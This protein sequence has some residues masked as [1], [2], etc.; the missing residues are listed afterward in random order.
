MS[1]TDQMILRA[2]MAALVLAVVSAS[3]AL[4]QRGGRGAALLAHTP[5]GGQP[6]AAA[7]DPAI[8][9]DG[10][11]DRYAAYS[12]AATDIVRGSGAHRNIF[13]VYRRTP[14]TKT[15]SPWNMGKTVLITKGRGGP[16]NG[17]SWGPSFD[18]YDYAHAGREI[19]VAPKCLAFVSAASNLVRGDGNH[20]ADVFVRRMRGGRLTRIAT[21]GS[22]SEVA[23][24]GR[25]WFAAYVSGGTVY[26]KDLRHGGAAKRISQRGG[27]SSPQLSANGKVT[28]YS[29]KGVVYVNRQGEGGTHRIGVGADPTSDDWG[30]LVAFSRGSDI[31]QASTKGAP[32]AHPLLSGAVSPSMTAAGHFV[33]YIRGGSAFTT[34]YAFRGACPSGEAQ[35][36]QGSPHGNYAVYSCSSG[37]AMLGYVGPR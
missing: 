23:L 12:S 13:V 35:Q 4:A 5:A 6:N 32:R 22:A 14:L 17:D 3:P 37:A 18:G 31:W 16:A 30:K 9:G 1:S 27:A 11:M 25:C 29:R 15:G 33:F 2:V 10:R 36:V 34:N 26:L 21:A 19:T 7:T 20:H 24:D 8:S 28:T